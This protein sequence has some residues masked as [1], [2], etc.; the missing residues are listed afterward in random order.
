MYF[1][2]VS[3]DNQTTPYATSD[4]VL[5]RGGGAFPHPRR[6]G[7][8]P[9]WDSRGDS[10]GQSVVPKQAFVAQGLLGVCFGLDW[11]GESGSG[12]ADAQAGLHI[13]RAV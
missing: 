7:I 6:S 5:P 8:V 13:S 3:H 9:C 2:H 10:R 4:A 11:P 12:L 1:S